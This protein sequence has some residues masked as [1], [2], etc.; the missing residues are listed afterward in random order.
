MVS[1]DVGQVYERSTFHSTNV[2]LSIRDFKTITSSL[3]VPSSES[4]AIKDLNVQLDISHTRDSDLRVFL[5]SPQGN[6]IELF[7][8]VG[9]TSRDFTGT[10]VDDEADDP[11]TAGSGAIYRHLPS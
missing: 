10:I 1:I 11:I 9:G 3:T 8:D 6:R 5:I 2:P 7:T 4:Y